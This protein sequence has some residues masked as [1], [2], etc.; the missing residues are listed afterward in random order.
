MAAQANFNAAPVPVDGLNIFLI[1]GLPAALTIVLLGLALS[2]VGWDIGRT[3]SLLAESKLSDKSY[4]RLVP[5]AMLLLRILMAAPP[6]FFI[7]LGTSLYQRPGHSTLG[8]CILIVG[9][10]IMLLVWAL[11][12]ARYM[13]WNGGLNVKVATTI[14][15]LGLLMAQL[16]FAVQRTT[17][18]FSFSCAFL[19][20]S[21]VPVIV[22]GSLNLEAMSDPMLS[23]RSLAENVGLSVSSKDLVTRKL[24]Y[25]EGPQPAIT[26]AKWLG[27]AGAAYAIIMGAY[28][29]IGFALPK[30][31]PGAQQIFASQPD[32]SPGDDLL[33]GFNGTGSVN[34]TAS[35]GEGEPISAV[36]PYAAA[37]AAACI[38][39]FDALALALRH[40]GAISTA[41][42]LA[43]LCGGQRLIITGYGHDY[44]DEG[45]A[46]V[47]L[48]HTCVLVHRLVLTRWVPAP[49]DAFDRW[50]SE[51]S[52]DKASVAE[53]EVGM[54]V[55]LAGVRK[56]ATEV[57]L[58]LLLILHLG[59]VL[60]FLL[61]L[62]PT[63]LPSSV[64]LGGKYQQ[65]IAGLLAV[66]LL[67][68]YA[69]TEVSEPGHES[70]DTGTSP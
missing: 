38:I 32:S 34:G 47:F 39:L 40:R 25:G 21:A 56:H 28:A 60:S 3:E 61:L 58:A 68:I 7:L 2:R 27:G 15:L 49:R 62:P 50:L 37:V 55:I 63:I 10:S 54:G 6:A 20:L 18:F 46:F 52:A 13:C 30:A 36:P 22:V 69:M 26:L 19:G 33:T 14:G 64:L 24:R 51:L 5:L 66:G 70:P 41:A 16:L 53:P 4:A 1:W 57:Q 59:L 44:I 11:L 8:I 31:L 9:P 43:L 45:E 29:G 67:A 65:S 17:T 35:G 42:S 23:L 48:L 12:R